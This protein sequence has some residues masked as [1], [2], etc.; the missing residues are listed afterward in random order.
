[1]FLY[2]HCKSRRLCRFVILC[3][4]LLTAGLSPWCRAQDFKDSLFQSR[5][6]S[7]FSYE[8]D[9][10]GPGESI[11][12]E[13]HDKI[14]YRRSFGLANLVTKAKFTETTVSNVGSI[15]KTFVAYG[16]L[17][18]RDEGKLSLEDSI[19]EYFPDFK[20]KEIAR[21]VKI[22]HLLTHTSGL[23]DSRNVDGDSVFYLT[24][25]DEQ[26]F[27]PLKLSDTLEFEP[28]SRWNYSNPAFNGLALIIEKVSGIKW[29]KYIK[30]NIFK[31]AGMNN[32][33]I[34]DGTYPAEGVA[35]G[36]RPANVGWEEYDYGEYPTFNAAGNGGVWSSI[37][38]LRKY[39]RAMNNATFLDKKTITFSQTLWR[40]GNWSG[41]VLRDEWQDSMPPLNGFSWFVEESGSR[42][43]KYKNKLVYHRGEQAGFTAEFGMIPGHDAI[44]I[45][46][47]NGLALHKGY[48]SIKR[49]YVD[50][51]YELLLEMGY[52]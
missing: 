19:I 43:N 15:S 13:L 24:A 6:D 50:R 8:T 30:E 5:V 16:I 7:L 34:T 39:Y 41:Q 31:P 27:A 23:P 51:I 9:E 44:I 52:L 25:N 40:P 47:S 14:L 29:Q 18:L 32:S 35:H 1:M 33:K 10:N 11:L 38:D 4:A 36:Y 20:N 45:I 37:E 48:A 28:G 17:K 3:L 26:N 22:K 12:I 46:E 2:A 21:S 42:P 49:N